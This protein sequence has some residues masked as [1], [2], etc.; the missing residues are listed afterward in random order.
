MVSSPTDY[1]DLDV[2]NE[3]QRLEEALDDLVQTGKWS[4]IASMKR[5]SR[6]SSSAFARR[7]I[8]SSTMSAMAV[9]MRLGD[10]GVLMLEDEQGRGRAVSGHE[11]GTLL[12]DHRSLRLAVLNSCEGARNLVLG[13]LRRDGSEP[14]TAGNSG[15]DRHAVRDLR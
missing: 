7:H 14:R 10:D 5:A 4:S 1:L 13:S 3:Y 6:S 8:T 9:S 15:G 12:H 2:E 11:L